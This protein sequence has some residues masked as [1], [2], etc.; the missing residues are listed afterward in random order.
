MLTGETLADQLLTQRQHR[1]QCMA[2]VGFA[3][4]AAVRFVDAIGREVP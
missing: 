2:R 3:P 1:L 4:K